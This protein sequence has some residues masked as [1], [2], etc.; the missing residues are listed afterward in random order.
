MQEWIV[1]SERKDPKINVESLV[2]TKLSI[3]DL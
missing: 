3:T 2:L 1:T